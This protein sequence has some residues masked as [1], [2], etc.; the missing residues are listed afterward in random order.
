MD[1]I[2]EGEQINESDCSADK[3]VMSAIYRSN[4]IKLSSKEV[5]LV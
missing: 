3:F 5:V 2:L 1:N 4:L